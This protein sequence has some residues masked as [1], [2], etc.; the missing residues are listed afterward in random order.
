MV[1][2]SLCIYAVAIPGVESLVGRE[3]TQSLGARLL[4]LVL[5]AVGAI[6]NLFYI[7]FTLGNQMKV[8]IVLFTSNSTVTFTSVSYDVFNSHL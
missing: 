4:V 7:C 1:R 3:F 8:Y 5:R 2:F 6:F